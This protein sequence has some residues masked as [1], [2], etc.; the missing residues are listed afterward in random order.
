MPSS[1]LAL[2]LAPGLVWAQSGITG[3]AKDTSGA[4]L[5][6]V[7][8]EAASPVLIEKVRSAVTDAAGVYRIVD[9]RPGTY[10]VTFTLPGFSTFKRDGVELPSEFTAT[11]NADMAVGA[12]EET[13]TV[14]GEAPVVDI[15][16]SRAQTQFAEETLQSIPGTGRLATLPAIMP[17]VTL[18]RESDRGVGGLSDRTQTAYSVHGAPEAQPVV[19]GMNHQITGLTSGVYVYNQI[20]IQEVVVETS[21]VGAD[22]DTGGMQ[23]NMISKDGGNVFSGTANFSYVGPDLEWSNLNDELLARNL[24]PQRIG[25]VKKFRDSAAAVG[26]PIKRD[27]LWVFGAFRE[28]VTQQ[29]AEGIYDNLLLQPGMGGNSFLYE[30]DRSKPTYSNDYSKDVTVRFTWQAAAKHKIVVAGSFQPNCNCV[31][32]LLNPGTRRTR[33]AAGPHHYSPNYVP[34]YSWTLSRDEPNPDRSWWVG[35]RHQPARH[36]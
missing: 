32:N 22:R 29:Y 8:V 3:V 13:I 23:L 19:D 25:S 2:L 4:V 24:D 27:K 11:V 26:G 21:G 1:Y 33:E 28:G 9:L 17:G 20:G 34:S 12:L 18:R 15:R 6:G 31:F 16:S 5:P 35:K 10:T 14:S 36:A 30:Q 7:T